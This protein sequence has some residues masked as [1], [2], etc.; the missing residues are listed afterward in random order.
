MA[1][2]GD[3][4]ERATGLL[5]EGSRP[6][7]QGARREGGREA[8]QREGKVRARAAGETARRG[9]WRRAART[10]LQSPDA[11]APARFPRP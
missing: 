7:L 11:E 3:A 6:S 1:G 2:K 8:V 4:Q 5:E 10:P 9:G